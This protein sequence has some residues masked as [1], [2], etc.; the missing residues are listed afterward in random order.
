MGGGSPGWT[1]TG[2]RRHVGLYLTCCVYQRHNE[3][4]VLQQLDLIVPPKGDGAADVRTIK[5]LQSWRASATQVLNRKLARAIVFS[6]HFNSLGRHQVGGAW[7]GSTAAKR[8]SGEQGNITKT[9]GES[10]LLLHVEGVLTSAGQEGHSFLK[11]A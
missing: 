1:C 6:D 8:S 2:R 7:V 10:V 5:G 11:R 3:I 9:P 4:H